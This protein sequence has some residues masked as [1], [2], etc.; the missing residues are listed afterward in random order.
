MAIT[1]LLA[2]VVI[3]LVFLTEGIKA[4][5]IAVGLWFV[6]IPW[7]V[8]YFEFVNSRLRR[9]RGIQTSGSPGLPL[10]VVG[11]VIGWVLIL[12]GPLALVLAYLGWRRIRNAGVPYGP[13]SAAAAVALVVGSLGTLYL[14]LVLAGVA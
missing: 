4:D 2:G 13:G 10:A 12:M 11:L 5:H 3:S 7:T 14:G 6:S 8:G 9:S 1:A